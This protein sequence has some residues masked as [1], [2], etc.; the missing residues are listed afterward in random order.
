MD[1]QVGDKVTYKIREIVYTQIVEN[2]SI[3]R[4]IK[5]NVEYEIIKI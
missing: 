5:N 1:I 4:K 3:A 2:S